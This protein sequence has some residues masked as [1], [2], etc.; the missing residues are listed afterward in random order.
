[1]HINEISLRAES[2]HWNDHGIN[3]N[4]N[5]LESDATEALESC[6]KDI[7]IQQSLILSNFMYASAER[8]FRT[9]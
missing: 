9:H 4:E 5:T 6:D 7:F 2:N 8:S 3:M 1:M